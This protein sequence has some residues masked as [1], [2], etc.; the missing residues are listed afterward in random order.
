MVVERA[1]QYRVHAH[2]YLSFAR[3]RARPGC[4]GLSAHCSK[5]GARRGRG[6]CILGLI[7]V[8]SYAGRFL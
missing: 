3:A 1:D 6:F 4:G 7:S 5:G 2:Q 8:C